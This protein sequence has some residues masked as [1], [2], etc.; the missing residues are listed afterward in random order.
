MNK[1]IGR[2]ALKLTVMKVFTL[3]ISLLSTMLLSYFRSLDEYG[4]YSQIVMVVT[5]AISIFALGFPNSINY[6]LASAETRNEKSDFLSTYFT[7]NT[8]VSL[9]SGIILIALT[10]FISKYF[11]N[12]SISKFMF[13]LFL[14]PWINIINSSFD[15]FLIVEKKT[16]TLMIYRVIRGLITLLIIIIAYQFKWSF[17]LYMKSFIVSESIFTII[18]YLIVTR[19]SHT[20]LVGF[21]YGLIKKILVF[22]I[23]LGLS[24]IVGTLSIQ[25][26]KLMVGYFYD[27]KTLA[28]CCK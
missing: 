22:S 16:W 20:N 17:M 23:P 14:L 4:T 25:A 13:V 24:T 2:D 7:F 19:E 11:N 15:N 12:A 10:P 5:L 3:I 6:F 26:D 1:S 28:I 18:I 21:D 9:F 8:L 27:T